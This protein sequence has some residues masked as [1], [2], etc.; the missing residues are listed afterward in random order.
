MAAAG[1]NANGAARVV[2]GSI[3]GVH[4]VRGWLKVFSHTRPKE[5]IFNYS[6]WLIE[7][8]GDWREHRL[9][10]GRV[11]GKGLIARLEGLADRDEVLALLGASVAVPRAQLAPLPE[12]EYY[13]CD[14]I[15]CTVVDQAGRDLGRVAQILETGANDVLV[16]EGRERQLLPL[17]L[18]KIVKDVD[19]TQRRIR[20]DWHGG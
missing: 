12:G 19:L 7:S 1:D 3:A 14:L 8:A 16:V 20:V 11:H 18:E 9:L 2:V 4:G 5:N 6:P 13:W 15:G 17:V 10:E